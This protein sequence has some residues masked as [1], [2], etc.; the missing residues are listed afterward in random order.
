MNLNVIDGEAPVTPRHRAA[1]RARTAP[2][3]KRILGSTAVAMVTAMAVVLPLQGSADAAPTPVSTGTAATAL[4]TSVTGA[5]A[6]LMTSGAAVAQY[7]Q[8]VYE[9][10]LQIWVNRARHARGIRPIAVRPCHDGYAERW[11]NYLA[12]NNQFRHQDLGPYMQRC[13]LTGAGEILA[14]GPVRPVRMVRMWLNSPE[15][16]RI[17]LSRS[18]GLSGIAARRDSKG[19][20]IGCIDFGHR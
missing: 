11:T 4:S 12:R 5:S 20:W 16:R 3:A 7:R 1:P 2:R 19:N 13:K 18:Y 10:R 14:L 8:S 9:T 17:M 6:G 15:H